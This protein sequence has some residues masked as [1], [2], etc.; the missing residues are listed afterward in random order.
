[1]RQIGPYRVERELGR[2]G[3]G[4][5]YQALD[6]RLQRRVAIKQ[7]LG[8]PAH[9]E[10]LLRFAREAELLARVR[11]PNLI[12]IHELARS[13]EG[14][15][16]VTELIEGESLAE[17]LRRGPLPAP[18]AREL[19]AELAEG[20]AALHEAGI[21]HRDIKPE[22]VLLRVGGSPVLLDFGLARE[23]DANSL[24]ETGVLL[25]TPAYMSPEQARGLKELGPETDAYALGALLYAA[26]HGRA[27]YQG[28]SA[29]LILAALAEGPPS[30]SAEVDAALGRLGRDCMARDP[31]RRP[32]AAALA[33]RLRAEPARPRALGLLALGALGALGA[34]ALGLRSLGP[35]A[36]APSPLG[37]TSS[38]S[39]APRSSP[40]PAGSPK[41]AEGGVELS[42]SALL[43]RF[44]EA[45][46]SDV[47]ELYPVPGGVVC[48]AVPEELL[49]LRDGRPPRRLLEER[50]LGV[51]QARWDATRRRLVLP[52][53][54][55]A[56]PAIAIDPRS[57]EREL[58]RSIQAS[59]FG[60]RGERVLVGDREVRLTR[61]DAP[62]GAPP[63]AKRDLGAHVDL[64]EGTTGGWVVA[65]RE[66]KI[67]TK[68]RLQLLDPETLALQEELQLPSLRVISSL[69][70][71][72]DRLVLGLDDGCL[73]QVAADLSGYRFYEPAQPL[74]SDLPEFAQAVPQRAHL[75]GVTALALLRGEFLLSLAGSREH[76]ATLVLW[77]LEERRELDRLAL[78]PGKGL[79]VV[80]MAAWDDSSVALG[81]YGGGVY[82]VRLQER[83][84]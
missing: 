79:T 69:L 66:T 49:Y 74:P 75:R 25:G 24:T 26:L 18:E 73:V 22:N 14:P 78:F 15:Y 81:R 48:Y 1:M 12:E 53:Y 10:A 62:A 55:H 35:R 63:L 3:M 64:I 83:R 2:G 60:L 9:G 34:L 5:V 59:T 38:S 36:Q 54:A 61:V 67:R 8:G 7:V 57:G 30:W 47:P 19:L 28:A 76:D 65:L 32:S 51:R 20:V 84:P 33:E 43:L 58:L 42:P 31:A 13:E 39:G 72:D 40:S 27:P 6:P 82:R 50:D 70:L 11:H 29:L 21:V 45:E 16:L 17:R 37:S 80:R 52:S 56:R 41:G 23:L 46:D 71:S 68:T 4:V 44:E 77:S